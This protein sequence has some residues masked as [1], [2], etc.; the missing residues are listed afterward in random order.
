MQAA[1]GNNELCKFTSEKLENPSRQGRHLSL[2]GASNIQ[3][4]ITNDALE[5]D[6]DGEI[7]CIAIG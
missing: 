3:Q 7:S 6:L 4:S 2:F 1:H 5:S